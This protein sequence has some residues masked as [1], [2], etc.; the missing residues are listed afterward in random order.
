M[1]GERGHPIGAHSA[2]LAKCPP[3]KADLLTL[4]SNI[5]TS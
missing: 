2:G 1:A 5:D 4:G 3:E